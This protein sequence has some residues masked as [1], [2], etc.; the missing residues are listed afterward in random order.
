MAEKPEEGHKGHQGLQGTSQPRA[1]RFSSLLSL[2]SFMSL[3]VSSPELRVTNVVEPPSFLAICG[4]PLAP[5]SRPQRLGPALRP[6][7]LRVLFP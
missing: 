4:R 1:R 2:R 6:L 3:L 5:R 7:A